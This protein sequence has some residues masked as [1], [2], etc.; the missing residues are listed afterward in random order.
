[1]DLVVGVVGAVRRSPRF[2]KLA[3]VGSQPS[4]CKRRVRIQRTL[5][6]PVSMR[7]LI[8]DREVDEAFVCQQVAR[9]IA[10]FE[11]APNTT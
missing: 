6:A 1:M 8:T 5:L 2:V 3:L 4:L 11:H 7:A 10:A 9:T